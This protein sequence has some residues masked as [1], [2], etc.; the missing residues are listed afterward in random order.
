ML[1]ANIRFAMSAFHEGQVSTHETFFA[2][3]NV[4]ETVIDRIHPGPGLLIRVTRLV[5][6]VFDQ[7]SEARRAKLLGDERLQ[8]QESVPMPYVDL[9]F[10]DNRIRYVPHKRFI[11]PEEMN[12]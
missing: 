12:V 9:C 11:H 10:I 1:D 7:I 5:E 2:D 4:S 8:S 3:A 6:C